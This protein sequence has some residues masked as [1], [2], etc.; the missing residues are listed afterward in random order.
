MVMETAHLG[1]I[2]GT[3]RVRLFVTSGF[4]MRLKVY[5]THNMPSSSFGNLV[6]NN[7]GNAVHDIVGELGL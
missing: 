3:Y 2:A 6:L 5:R 4:P 7:V 1:F